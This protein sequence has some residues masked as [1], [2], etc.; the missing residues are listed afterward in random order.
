M[1]EQNKFLFVHAKRISL[2]ENVPIK[3]MEQIFSAEM[4]KLYMD[5]MVLSMV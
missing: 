3:Q 4:S 5:P 2:S 1:R